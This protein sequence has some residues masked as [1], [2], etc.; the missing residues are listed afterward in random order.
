MTVVCSYTSDFIFKTSVGEAFSCSINVQDVVGSTVAG[1]R[2]RL[3][4]YVALRRNHVR[5]RS[6]LCHSHVFSSSAG[7]HTQ[8]QKLLL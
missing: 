7:H 3:E 2:K 4:F 1:L 6:A 5:D 8:L